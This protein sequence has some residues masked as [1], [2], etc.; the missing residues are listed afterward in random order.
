MDILP[1]V[2]AICCILGAIGVIVHTNS[3]NKI[4]MFA[5]L[6]SGL[7]G[8]IASS[9]YLDVA[10]VSSIIEPISSVVLLLGLIKYEAVKKSKKKYG[11][12]LPILAK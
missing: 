4:I 3:I 1:I 6:E 2:S 8:L 9:Y 7:I 12:K 11:R 5:F 10:I